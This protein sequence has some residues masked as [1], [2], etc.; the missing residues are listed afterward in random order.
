M[1]IHHLPEGLVFFI[2][3]TTDLK[4]GIVIGLILIIHVIPEGVAIGVTAIEAHPDQKW[5]GPLYGLVAG[6][7]QPVGALIGYLVFY[8]GGSVPSNTVL[9]IV[10][11][12]T[13]GM[14]LTI[15]VKGLIPYA[16][17]IDTEDKV[18]TMSL[19]AGAFIIFFSI[20]MFGVAGFNG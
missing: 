10:F 1:V 15:S 14:L 8:R 19:F 17:R 2:A 11:G 5:R 7:A 16:R 18:T 13:S 9:G 4:S 20:S 3:A 12:I 6:L